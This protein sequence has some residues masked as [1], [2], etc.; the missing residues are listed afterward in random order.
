M[1]SVSAVQVI[2]H[3]APP[4]QTNGTHDGLPGAPA[5]ATVQVPGT[6]LHEEQPPLHADAQ[7]KPLAQNPVAHAAAA[8]QAVP[9]AWRA[10]Q[11]PAASQ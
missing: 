7:Q 10:T 11:V 2:G 9:A 6:T 4:L 1:Q 8:V 3:A 5:A